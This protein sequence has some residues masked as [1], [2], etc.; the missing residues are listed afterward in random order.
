MGFAW[1]ISD[2]AGTDGGY[3]LVHLQIND[4][5][6]FMAAELRLSNALLWSRLTSLK[7]H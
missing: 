5:A 2:C 6:I 1:G 4:L 3:Q 7:T